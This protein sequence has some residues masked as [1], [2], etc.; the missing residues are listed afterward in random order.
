MRRW[1]MKLNQF[2][3]IYYLF[4]Y[5]YNTPIAI[6]LRHCQEGWLNKIFLSRNKLSVD[7]ILDNLTTIRKDYD[8]YIVWLRFFTV[9]TF[10]ILLGGST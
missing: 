7:I 9:L 2:V 1:K 6:D 4:Y 3:W 8:I 5:L 10:F